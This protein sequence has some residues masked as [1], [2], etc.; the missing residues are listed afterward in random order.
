MFEPDGRSSVQYLGHLTVK[1]LRIF[2]FILGII[3]ITPLAVFVWCRTTIKAQQESVRLWNAPGT[4][5]TAVVLDFN[6][7]DL[8]PATIASQAIL[9]A[10][11]CRW[12]EIKS[13]AGIQPALFSFPA[14]IT[15]IQGPPV[16][17]AYFWY[18]LP[19]ATGV[20]YDLRRESSAM[21]AM[22]QGWW[23]LPNS[24]DPWLV[25][26]L[27]NM[28]PDRNWDV[29]SGELLIRAKATANYAA[30]VAA[31]DTIVRVR[32]WATARHFGRNLAPELA[33]PDGFWLIPAE[34]GLCLTTTDL[35]AEDL[36]SHQAELMPKYSAFAAIYNKVFVG[37][38]PVVVLHLQTLK[39]ETIRKGNPYSDL[40]RERPNGGCMADG[41]AGLQSKVGDG[42]FI[43][44]MTLGLS[45]DPSR[46]RPEWSWADF[47]WN[48]SPT[49][50]P[51]AREAQEALLAVG[52]LE[53]WAPLLAAEGLGDAVSLAQVRQI[54]D[55]LEAEHRRS[56]R[57][58]RVDGHH[59][60]NFSENS[61]NPLRKDLD[62][63]NPHH[64]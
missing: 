2:F 33:S 28:A 4:P 22:A 21:D 37:H 55:Y 25:K 63:Y 51:D 23:N 46:G 60:Y 45:F 10:R 27:W 30:Y 6:N 56:A 17:P 47:L 57:A 59:F 9:V 15:T 42:P 14:R 7:P 39:V 43:T 24:E 40:F 36:E 58:C 32:T 8:D 34:A 53:F 18:N 19:V 41:F 35:L 5:M 64:W 13:Q 44:G 62:D 20:I 16:S 12:P 3:L 50:S 49:S 29:G 52:K 48:R 31:V 1:A 61:L 38:L 11:R 54:L 26:G